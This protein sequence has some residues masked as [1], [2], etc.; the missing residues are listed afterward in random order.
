MKIDGPIKSVVPSPVGGGTPRNGKS[1]AGAPGS[2]GGDQVQL[3]QLSSQ[4]QAL[5]SNMADSPVV[6]AAR[7]AEIRQ[8]IADGLFRVNPDVV[9]D[10]LLETARELLRSR[11]A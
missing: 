1:A 6:D 3:S 7:V 5:E 8:A 4:L 9:A 10:H 11:Q 2:G